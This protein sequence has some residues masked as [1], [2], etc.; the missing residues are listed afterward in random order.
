MFQMSI[1][2]SI[3]CNIMDSAPNV[4]V[5]VYTCDIFS[6][7]RQASYYTIICLIISKGQRFIIRMTFGCGSASP[8]P[9]GSPDR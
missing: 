4:L 9:Y 1:R 7:F 5:F 2:A 8:N 3:E 6:V